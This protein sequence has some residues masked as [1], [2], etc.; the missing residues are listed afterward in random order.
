M[1]TYPWIEVLIVI[2]VAFALALASALITKRTTA[3]FAAGFNVMV[4]VIAVLMWRAPSFHLRALI[5]VLLAAIYLARLNWVILV[6]SKD[7]AMSKLDQSVP[8]LGKIGLSFILVHSVG[9]GYCVPFYFIGL[10]SAPVGWWDALAVCVYLV[11]TWFHF[12]GDYQ[13][14][15]FKR[16][17]D[18]RGKLLDTG[19]WSWCRHP[20]YFGDFLIY[21]SF[22][23]L[24]QHPYAWLCP[25]LNLAQYLF[26]AIPKNEAWAADKYGPAWGAYKRRTPKFVPR[27]PSG[28]GLAA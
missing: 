13:K 6:W 1:T 22:A 9:L 10:D 23:V 27:P 18:T 5:A 11:G 7:T 15:R 16:R 2:E 21:V 8:P 20:N 28:H 26:D 17:P 25:L 14:V 24:A 3:I 4:P 12:G 19:L